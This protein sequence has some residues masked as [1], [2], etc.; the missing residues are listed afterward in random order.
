MRRSIYFLLLLPLVPSGPLA[1]DDVYLKNGRVF[2]DVVTEVA[3]GS[4]LVYLPFGEMRLA[5]DA[6]ERIESGASSL[7]T[8]RERRESLLAD[9]SAGAAEWLELAHW[10][11]ASGLRHSGREAALVAAELDPAA[12]G[13]AEVMRRLDYV[14]DEHLGRWMP[15]AESMRLRGFELV[16]GVWLSPEQRLELA[17]AEAEAE[18]QREADQERRLTQAVLALAAAQLA[19]EPEPEVEVPAW[20]AGVY[21]SPFV[22]HQPGFA[23]HPRPEPHGHRPPASESPFA[24]P[25]EQRQPGSL[26]PVKSHH[27][28]MARGRTGGR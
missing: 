9:A 3:D 18:R 26:F 15:F 13:L 19:S 22:W 12:E 24:I 2:E 1:A 17:R 5:L 7:A 4:L 8:F 16:D 28:G 27:G 21:A 11:L 6:V 23:P 14:L 25:I 20:G 10:G